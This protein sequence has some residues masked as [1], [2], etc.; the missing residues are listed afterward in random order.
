MEQVCAFV[1]ETTCFSMLILRSAFCIDDPQNQPLADWYGIV[2]GTSHEE[3]M[4]RSI[5]VEWDLFGNG[6]A[7]DYSTNQQRIYQFWVVGAERAAPYEGIFTIG[8]R[9]D[10]DCKRFALCNSSKR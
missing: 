10:G 3:P 2:M 6:T 1:R 4:M 9:G 5:P 7:W 8:M